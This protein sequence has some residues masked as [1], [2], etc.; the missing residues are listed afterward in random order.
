ML[1]HA[2]VVVAIVATYYR[3]YAPGSVL[4]NS[5]YTS[6][7][8][9]VRTGPV[10][11]TVFAISVRDQFSSSNLYENIKKDVAANEKVL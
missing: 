6:V 1:Y 9:H 5:K 3:F 10:H 7:W 4:M 2:I 8:L 11:R